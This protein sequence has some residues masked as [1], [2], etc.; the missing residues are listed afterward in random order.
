MRN[1]RIITPIEVIDRGC[2]L[3]ENSFIAKICR[4]PCVF[5]QSIDSLD[6]RDHTVIP[7]FIDTHIH[8]YQGIDVSSSRQ[9]EDL[10]RLGKILTR[11]GITSF[12]PSTVSLDHE[13]L[14]RI[15]SIVREAIDGWSRDSGSARILGLHL[16]GPYIN[17]LMRGIH[18]VEYIRRPSI[19][20][21]NEYISVSGNSIRKITIAPELDGA[22]KLIEFAIS[23]GIVVSAGHTNA[24]FEEGLKAIE[25]GIRKAT[26]IFNAMRRFHHRDPGIALAL[27][28]SPKIFIEI[29]PD[30]VH[31][32][33]SVIKFVV[34]YAG[35]DR[36]V[37]VSDAIGV[38]GLPK[39][40]YR[41]Y[42]IDIVVEDNVLRE[43]S[44]GKLAGSSLTM[45]RALK[46]MI[47][48]GYSIREV[49]YMASYVP[50]KSVY[51]LDREKLGLLE[52]GYRADIVVLDQNLDISMTIIDGVVVYSR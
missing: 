34:D 45:D 25:L 39:G 28:Q 36:V 10:I 7:G 31:L 6:L 24:T 15:C 44:T 40:R 43:A 20:E 22:H 32:H 27:L 19:E 26:H 13:T 5:P 35:I 50:G 16:E 47:S 38:A 12:I 33:P 37:L 18:R 1:C 29:I 48:L 30:L 49:V 21:L 4:E 41:L 8:G 2:I 52:P 51:A 42:G 11:F 3:I 17:P 46:N 9:P 23:K 14:L